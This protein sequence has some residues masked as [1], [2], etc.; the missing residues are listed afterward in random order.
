MKG[1]SKPSTY[2]AGFG[3]HR[4]HDKDSMGSS[5][6][7]S[8]DYVGKHVWVLAAPLAHMNL[9]ACEKVTEL[10]FVLK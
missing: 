8:P 5:S 4:R 6:V 7:L 1:T 3:G 9:G 2:A 10:G